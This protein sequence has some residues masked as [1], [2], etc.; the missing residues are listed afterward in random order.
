MTWILI[1]VMLISQ[2]YAYASVPC[3][4]N[5]DATS[6]HNNDMNAMIMSDHSL[7]EHDMQSH[8]QQDMQKN[9]QQQEFSMDCCDEECSCPTGT[10]SSATLTHFITVTAL[11]SVSEPSGFYLFL[12]QE[13]FLPSL[14][15]PPIIS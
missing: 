11:R 10:Y 12:L 1:M 2:S 6:Q 3:G 14:R 4:S 9:T 7:P 5:A 13:T 15:K 8:M